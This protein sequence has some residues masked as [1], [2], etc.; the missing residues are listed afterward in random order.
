MSVH[1]LVADW[2]ASGVED[3]TPGWLT[4][5][6]FSGVLADLDNTLAGYATPE[7]CAEIKRWAASLNAAGIPLVVVSNNDEERV[8]RFCSPLGTPYI[9]KAGK[10]RPEGLLAAVELS[11]QPPDKVLMIGDQV[12]T[13]VRAAGRA[14]LCVAIVEPYTHGFWVRVRRVAENPFITY[15]RRRQSR[16][17]N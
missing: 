2:V 5:H 9:A 7:P 15:A 4:R 16:R 3:F 13:D 12:F 1:H 6:G 17:G 11:G 14:G 8:S 10:P